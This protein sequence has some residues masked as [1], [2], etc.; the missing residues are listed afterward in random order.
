[1]GVLDVAAAHQGLAVHRAEE[2]AH[3]EDELVQPNPEIAERAVRDGE[4]L[5]QIAAG[6]LTDPGG[7]R[8][9]ALAEPAGL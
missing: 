5:G 9:D 7:K 3:P 4:V 8:S 6:D 1:M 2:V